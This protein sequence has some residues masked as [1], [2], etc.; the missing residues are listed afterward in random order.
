[1]RS[2]SADF[3]THGPANRGMC[4]GACGK[5][6]HLVTHKNIDER[7]IGIHCRPREIRIPNSYCLRAVRS[8]GDGTGIRGQNRTQLLVRKDIAPKDVKRRIAPG[9]AY[10]GGDGKVSTRQQAK[11]VRDDLRNDKDSVSRWSTYDH[12]G[13]ERH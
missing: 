6:G 12:G 5:W 11:D 9:P 10:S 8:L 7:R 4:E 1:M 13:R 2:L 3:D